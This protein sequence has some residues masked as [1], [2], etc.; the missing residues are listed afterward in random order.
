MNKANTLAEEAVRIA[1][2][3]L[4]VCYTFKLPR[5]NQIRKFRALYN[6]QVE[7]QLRIRYNVPIPIFAGMID[8]LQAYLNDSMVLKFTDD[9]KPS[10]WK[11]VQKANAALQK[12]MKSKN[13]KASWNAKMRSARKEML[14]S[15][16]G[17]LKHV[18]SNENGFSSILTAPTFEDMY[19][20]PKGGANLDNHLFVG[21]SDIWKTEK[22]FEDGAGNEYDRGQVKILSDMGGNE[23]KPSSFWQNSDY[24]NRFLSLN[25]TPE[26]SNYTGEKCFNMVEWGLT[27]KGIRWY[28][29]FEAFTGTWV[30]F[31]KLEDI[32]SDNQWPWL[33]FASHEDEKNFASKAFSDDLYPHARMM[34]DFFNE[35][36]ENKK[37]RN[38]NA[39][40]Y[41]KDMVPNVAQLDEA[42]MG[43]D[44]LVEF[45][46]KGG[47]RK[48]ADG[49]Y[50]FTTPEITGTVD[51][52]KYMEDL[53]GRNYGVTDIM[54]GAAQGSSKA[55][56]VSLIETSNVNQRLSFESEPFIEVGEQLA[57]RYLTGLRDYLREP[58]SIKI[59]GENGYQWDTLRRS[60]LSA[61]Q[62]FGITVTSQ[63]KQNK[64]NQMDH[65]KK[66]TALVTVRNTPAQNPN[67]NS[68]IVDEHILRDAGIDETEINLILDPHSHADKETIAETASAIEQIMQGK[69]PKINYDATAYFVQTV[70]DFVSTHRDDTKVRHHFDKFMAYINQ[71]VPIAQEN[72]IR[73]AKADAMRIKMAQLASGAPDEEQAQPSP[74][75]A[76]PAAVP[77][78]LLHSPQPQPA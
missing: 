51:T 21:Q 5:I 33:S 34:T 11:V 69:M 66:I 6:G 72:E 77:A 50:Q 68:K 73:R 60:E 32:F 3:Q 22:E 1:M 45:D 8:T 48:I 4:M 63:S 15:G 38:S 62:E 76:A 75:G 46:T 42:Q 18:A 53:V 16:R 44:R 54:Q 10:N 55:V 19:F 41:D 25:L 28:L 39:R 23:F 59:L 30:R 36:M 7:K 71:H 12:A 65:D 78:D 74:G 31:E 61:T 9:D 70:L 52:L 43:R 57:S 13:V 47:T 27:F 20:E 56:G 64:A 35:D 49:I 17:F 29:L 58:L 67:I 40:G 24:A 14:F 26:S 2:R 37:R